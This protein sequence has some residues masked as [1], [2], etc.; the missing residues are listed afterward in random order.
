MNR[1]GR[2][3]S[4][5]AILIL[6]GGGA[7]AYFNRQGIYDWYRLRDYTP[8]SEIVQ[9]ADDTTMTDPAR[10]LFY[11]QHP[12]LNDSAAFNRN[13][14]QV[15][16]VTIVLGCYVHGRGIF[17]FDV[18]DDPRLHG[19]EQVTA[20]HELLH[21]VYERLSDE[22]RTRIDDLTAIA[23]ENV[24]NERIRKNVTSYRDRDPSIVANELHSILGTEV[25][26]LPAELETYY[27]RYFHDRLR[28]VEY[29]ENYEAEFTKR[30][31]RA[32]T[33]EVQIAGIKREIDLLEASMRN[34]R[35][36]L[37][38][39]R[40]TVTTQAE[41]DAFN[42]RVS[43]YNGNI[44]RLNSLISQHNTLVAEYQAN[45]VEHQE[46]FEALSSRPTL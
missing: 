44:A 1:A 10:R 32:S 7:W 29:S 36:A 4:W 17:I 31:D 40:P 11:V 6:V 14:G 38:A 30:R 21:A 33:L 42:A 18:Q 27:K 37:D 19:V 3:L 45:A 34:E 25:R 46:L 12:E 22:E 41:A 43:A 24:T 13:C 5:L 16:E 35:A 20:A 23:F 39:I 26:H 2:I 9:L 15:S 28:I 8:P